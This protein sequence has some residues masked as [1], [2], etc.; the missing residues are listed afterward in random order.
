MLT[1]VLTDARFFRVR[2][3]TAYGV[4]LFEDDMEF[5]GALS[6]FHGNNERVGVSSVERTR[7]MLSGTLAN[8]GDRT[9]RHE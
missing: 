8:F 5:S 6:M 4:G 3:V 1:P 7:Q 9:G 2:G